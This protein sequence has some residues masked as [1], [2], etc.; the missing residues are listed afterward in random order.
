MHPGG[1]KDHPATQCCPALVVHLRSKGGVFDAVGILI[2]HPQVA[3]QRI[4]HLGRLAV[5]PPG[6]RG[7]MTVGTKK[8][9]AES[10]LAPYRSMI[11]CS[12]DYLGAGG[13]Y[14]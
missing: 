5:N 1:V 4:D 11:G 3:R 13:M 10:R 14:I 2:D 6:R 7:R 8:E 12:V 9:T